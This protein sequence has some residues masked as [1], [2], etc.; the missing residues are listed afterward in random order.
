MRVGARTLRLVLFQSSVPA[1]M[2]THP[3]SC[4]C[5]PNPQTQL[6][7]PPLLPVNP[8]ALL[9]LT[10]CVRVASRPSPARPARAC[11]LAARPSA[12]RTARWRPRWRRRG[13]A[14]PPPPPPTAQHRGHIQESTV[15]TPIHLFIASTSSSSSPAQRI[16]CQVSVK[17]TTP[18]PPTFHAPLM[19]PPGG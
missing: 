1:R 14:S 12:S 4:P 19:L 9:P 8:T 18:H 3:A 5:N 13:A 17:L 7:V 11:A 6:V 2:S 15:K 16:V 10:P